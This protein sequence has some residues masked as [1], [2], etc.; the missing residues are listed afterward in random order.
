VLIVKNFLL[1]YNIKMGNR[2][3]NP[4]ANKDSKPANCEPEEL[5]PPLQDSKRAE[6]V[7]K[8]QQTIANSD[9]SDEAKNASW[10]LLKDFSVK[11]EI[12]V[13]NRVEGEGQFEYTIRTF[14]E[15]SKLQRV[16]IKTISQLLKT[17]A[18][19][20]Q[21]DQLNNTDKTIRVLKVLAGYLDWG[22]MAVDAAPFTVGGKPCTTLLKE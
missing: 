19:S 11:N 16:G 12:R 8:I 5:L 13:N 6:L 21:W 3:S 4:C 22:A 1:R 18:L 2:P 15:N 17:V 7:C 10:A 14:K 9:L 20:S